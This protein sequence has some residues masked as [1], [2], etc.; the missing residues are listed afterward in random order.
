MSTNYLMLSDQFIKEAGITSS[1]ST[2]STTASLT[3]ELGRVVQWVLDAHDD[4]QRHH[5]NWRFLTA[6]FTLAATTGNNQ[7]AY[8]DCTDLVANS[9]ISRFDRWIMEDE[10]QRWKCYNTTTGTS[11]EYWLTYLPY[12]D[13]RKL[14]E[15][16]SV[17]NGV[18]AHVTYDFSD[19]LRVGPPPDNNYTITGWYYKGPLVFTDDSNVPEWPSQWHKLVIWWALEKYAYYEAAPEVVEQA[20]IYKRRMLRQ[21]EDNQLPPAKLPPPLC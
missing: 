20:K 7:Y 21:L 8:T 17:S 6:E 14:Y 12:E 4:I 15:L 18:P 2:L 9:A 10:D 11:G 3:G 1:T 13:W 19:R 16:G 5:N